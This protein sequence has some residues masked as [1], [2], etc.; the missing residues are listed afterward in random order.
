VFLAELLMAVCGYAVGASNPSGGINNQTERSTMNPS[1]WLALFNSVVTLIAAAVAAVVTYVIGKG[2]ADIARQQAAA[3]DREAKTSHN[4]L[5]LDLF[6]RRWGVYDA[7]SKAIANAVHTGDFSAEDERAYLLKIR[8][9]RWIFDHRT[10]AYLKNELYQVFN[11]LHETYVASREREARS[12]DTER[13]AKRN[14]ATKAVTDH[15]LAIDEKFGR[16]LQLET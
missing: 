1:D 16:Y 15:F 7:V 6:E 4:Q 5:K 14:A 2:Q 13:M 3:A 12:S 9:A 8:G 11:E 10:D